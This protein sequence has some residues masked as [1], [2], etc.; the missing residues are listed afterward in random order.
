MLTDCCTK[1]L[2][3]PAF[4]KQYAAMGV[5]RN[6]LGNSIGKGLSTLVTGYG[7]GIAPGNGIWNAV[8]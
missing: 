4:W 3:K 1:L 8:G 5:I 7:N 2:P 6:E